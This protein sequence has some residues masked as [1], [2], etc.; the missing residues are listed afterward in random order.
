MI[1][2]IERRL[3]QPKELSLSENAN[4]LLDC[5]DELTVIDEVTSV[6]EDLDI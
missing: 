3:H 4:N 2:F 1:H 5:I 6:V